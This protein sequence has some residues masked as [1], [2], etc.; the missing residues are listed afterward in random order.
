MKKYLFGLLVFIIFSNCKREKETTPQ[1]TFTDSACVK[2]NVKDVFDSLIV[3]TN[4]GSLFPLKD[5]TRS[6]VLINE[7]KPYYLYF[8]ATKPEL[9][10]IVLLDTFYIRIVP[11][12]TLTITVGKKQGPKGKILAY[13]ESDDP[14]LNYMKKEKTE[15][16][17]WIYE[18]PL[19]TAFP[20]SQKQLEKEL[21]S[22]NNRLDKRLEFL[23]KNKEKLPE[24]FVNL[25]RSDYK[26]NAASSRYLSYFYFNK[27]N[28]GGTYPPIDEALNNDSAKLSSY[29]YDFLTKY[30]LISQLD[31]NIS[32]LTGP[33]RLLN[34]YLKA[35]SELDKNLNG[36]ILNYFN[37]G[38]L[39]SCYS[40]SQSHSEI[41]SVDYF[42]KLHN[43]RL[44]ESE[45]KYLETARNNSL[46][47][48]KARTPFSFNPGDV[49]PIFSLFDTADVERKSSEFLGKIVYLHFWATW[50]QPC[51]IELP[52]INTLCNKLKSK[53]VVVIN[54]CIDDEQEKWMKII[55]T[56]KLQGVNLICRA[57]YGSMLLKKYGIKG[58]PHYT[59]LDRNSRLIKNGSKRPREVYNDLIALIK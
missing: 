13:Y 44:T 39:L 55:R 58:I 48:L 5:C 51:L 34:L 37:F 16:G 56:E 2:L 50:C 54:I 10:Q 53:D 27:M 42:R 25:Q 12:E 19:L 35:A 22:I 23:E 30:F 49:A 18:R 8:R 24:W 1:I 33:P 41:D 31:E 52:D 32:K 17:Y 40:A 20:A 11:K 21:L 7:K 43:L 15:F 26:Y 28:L 6:R 9:V 45:E 59:L 57:N 46:V 3:Y 14:I 4:Y 38:T 36:E 47:Q 29:Y